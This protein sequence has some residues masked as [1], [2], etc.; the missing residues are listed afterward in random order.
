MARVPE[1]ELERLK[2]EVSVER[3]AEARGVKLSRVG[4][5]LRG[6]C[7]FHEGD[8]EPSL[9]VDPGQNLFHCFGCGA[10]GSAVDWVMK[11]EGVSFRHAVELLRTDAPLDVAHREP[12]GKK[13]QPLKVSTVRRL[14][15]PISLEAEDRELLGQ[16]VDYYHATLK[17]SPE[18]L[19][20]LE[21]RGLKHPELVERFR[22][23][24]ANRTLGLRLPE[25]NRV[26]GGEIRSRLQRLGILRVSGHEHFNGCVV[27]PVFDAAGE[28]A[29]LYGRKI[30]A[31]LKP[32]I[33]RHLYLPVSF[34]PNP[35]PI[36]G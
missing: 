34:S 6:V 3:L 21:G 30:T 1:A 4:K 7:P 14:P 25:K 2:R 19:G 18:A 36:V 17:E 16:V 13:G 12:R 23:G 35:E 9:F 28:V 22:L 26:A 27:F 5:D 32:E 31:G 33:P 11:A 10:K 24:Y 29:G 15:P 8:R 20:Y